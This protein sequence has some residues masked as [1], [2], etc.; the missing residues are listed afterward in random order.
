MSLKNEKIESAENVNK[1]RSLCKE[2]CKPKEAMDLKKFYMNKYGNYMA[3]RIA[4]VL[5]AEFLLMFMIVNTGIDSIW[6]DIPYVDTIIYTIMWSAGGLYLA[7]MLVRVI[8]NTYDLKLAL[9]DGRVKKS[10]CDVALK[11]FETQR[12]SKKNKIQLYVKPKGK[13]EQVWF[14]IHKSQHRKMTYTSNITN[15]QAGTKLTIYSV[16]D[17]RLDLFIMLR[18]KPVGDSVDKQLKDIISADLLDKKLKIGVMKAQLGI[19]KK[20]NKKNK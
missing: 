19:G 10:T 16:D 18:D 7:Q 17:K 1:L 13:N 4:S 5:F 11:G 9:E 12:N 2:S 14:Y 15:E 8:K 6:N 3:G 20:K